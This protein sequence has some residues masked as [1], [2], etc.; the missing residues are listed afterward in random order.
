M[1]TRQKRNSSLGLL[2][3]P[4][5]CIALTSYFIYHSNQGRFSLQAKV[6][7]DQK[8]LD[9]KKELARAKEQ[10]EILVARVS[11]MR[12]GTLERDMLDEQARYHLNLTNDSEIIIYRQQK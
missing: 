8:A 11:L 1:S 6:E 10:R 9:L 4:A 2:V 3:I 7:L 12:I 5:I